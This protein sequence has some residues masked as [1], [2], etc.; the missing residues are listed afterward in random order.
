MSTN[1]PN[2]LQGNNSI[3]QQP[4]DS[5]NSVELQPVVQQTWDYNQNNN[6]YI[7][8][9]SERKKC[10]L[11]YVLFWILMMMNKKDVTVFEYRHLKQSIW[12]WVLFLMVFILSVV[13]IF[14]PYIKLL[15]ILPLFMMV[16]IRL[17]FIFQVWSWKYLIWKSDSLWFFGW[18]GWWILWLFES[19][20]K[21]TDSWINWNINYSTKPE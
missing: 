16:W 14:V 19:D 17:Y 11:M 18:L 8:S 10:V 4:L 13:F 6:V 12:R 2:S 9:S 3:Y 5:F 20:I 1:L 7:P 21:V 15:W